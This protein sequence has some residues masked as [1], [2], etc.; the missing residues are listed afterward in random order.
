MIRTAL[1][2]IAI[3]WAVEYVIEPG[4]GFAVTLYMMAG[5]IFHKIACAVGAV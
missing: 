4:G 2:T 5:D 3:L 1:V